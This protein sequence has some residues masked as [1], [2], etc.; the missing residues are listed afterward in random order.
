[1]GLRRSKSLNGIDAV[2]LF[3]K[4]YVHTKGTI[5]RASSLR[6]IMGTAMQGTRYAALP[7]AVSCLLAEV[8]KPADLL[9]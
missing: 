6:G 4:P 8:G 5:L 7:W 1:M 9:F 3:K 2:G